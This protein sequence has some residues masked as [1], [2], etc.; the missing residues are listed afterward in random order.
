MIDYTKLNQKP[1][2]PAGQC[3]TVN[4]RLKHGYIPASEQ[5]DVKAKHDYFKN[6]SANLC[7]QL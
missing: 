7:V 2:S 5:P 4:W 3:V 1:W 6:L